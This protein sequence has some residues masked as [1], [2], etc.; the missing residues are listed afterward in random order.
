MPE[1]VQSDDW[2]IYDRFRTAS[3]NLAAVVGVDNKVVL[4]IGVSIEEMVD[5]IE[6]KYGG[7]IAYSTRTKTIAAIAFYDTVTLI[8]EDNSL[9]GGNYPYD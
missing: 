4:S 6:A 8:I 1:H 9:E 5:D 7:D 2:Q 3:N